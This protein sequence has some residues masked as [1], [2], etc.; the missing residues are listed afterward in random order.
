[1]K[2]FICLFFY[3]AFTVSLFSQ[4]KSY[5]IDFGPNDVTN[6]NTTS[7]PDIN[8]NYWNNIIDP[9]TSG[10][11]I[12]LVD[13]ENGASDIEVKVVDNLA[14]NGIQNGGLLMP[15]ASLLG[16]YAIATATQDYFFTSSAG[17]L[18][19]DNLDPAKGYVFNIFASRNTTSIRKSKYV[20]EGYN[21]VIDSLQS[22]GPDLGGGGYNGNNSTVLTTIP[23]KPDLSGRIT[24]NMSV[25]E[26]EFAYVNLLLLSEVDANPQYLVDFGP[27]DVTNGNITTSPDDNGNYWN[28]MMLPNSNGDSLF[29][30]EKNSSLSNIYIKVTDDFAMNG[31]Q[32]GGL[33]MPED[34]LLGEF[35]IP[36]ATQ[37]YFFTT[38]LGSL[39]IGRLNTSSKYIFSFFGSRDSDQTRITSYELTGENNYSGNLQTSGIGIGAGGYNGNNNTILVTDTIY[40]NAEGKVILNMTVEAGGFAYLGCMRMEEFLAPPGPICPDQDSLL[41][42]VMGSSVALG[43]GASNNQGYAYNFTQL[44]NQRA[45]SGLGENWEVANISIGGNNTI[46]VLNRWDTDLRPLCSRYVI[47]GLSLGNEGITTQGQAAF[48]QFRDNMLVLID[49]ARNEGIEPVIMNNYTRNDFDATDYNFIKQINLLIHS[50]DVASFNTLGAVDDGTGKWTPG[51]FSD[52]WHPNT[53]GHLEFYY[54]MVP[55]LFDALHAGKAQPQKVN[56]T[57]M[58]ID[59][60]TSEYQLEFT[61]EEIVHPFTFSFDIRTSSTGSIAGY[62]TDDNGYGGLVIDQSGILNYTSSSS[63]G[64]NGS[65]SINDDN[66]HNIVLTH[67]Y[68]WGKTFLY[69]DGVLQ[70][71]VNEKL[72]TDKFILSEEDAPT[73]D[74]R[75]WLF[76]RSGMNQEEVNA[77]VNGELLKSSLE[78]YAPLDGQGVIGMDTLV[79]LAQSLNVIEQIDDYQYITSLDEV[80]LE[81]L[82]QFKI[83]PNPSIDQTN[84]QFQLQDRSDVQLLIYN[85]NGQ[86]VDLLVNDSLPTGEHSFSWNSDHRMNGFFICVLKINGQSQSLNIEILD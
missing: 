69:V 56:G 75:E 24:I 58:T 4:N 37:D 35:A 20:F 38:S 18:A 81:R 74:Y 49:Q 45:I 3:T 44:L 41:I 47:Y 8:G 14:S 79:N 62:T 26:G 36:T 59:K 53:A 34:P 10:T 85:T 22:S 2:N 23:I 73:A 67:Y 64:I 33:L 11:P 63:N 25:L 6:G 80:E 55:S 78:L 72:E 16:E 30:V 76:Y 42:A 48:D 40:P 65:A 19:F 13:K 51:Y 21:Q 43:V 39:E 61:P 70:G 7:S 32:N 46:D 27:N 60:S 83:F 29:L 5:L 15:D 9:T 28:N 52:A 57:Y 50:W 54:T 12:N 66:W 82:T 17:I 1:M 84:I 71:E 68:A 77:I 86:Q 31:I